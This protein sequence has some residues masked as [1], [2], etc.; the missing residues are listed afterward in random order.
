MQMSS[1]IN[2]LATHMGWK[3]TDRGRWIDPYGLGMCCENPPDPLNDANDCEALIGHLLGLGWS[4]VR[5]EAVGSVRVE[6]RNDNIVHSWHYSARDW[7]EGV[8]ELAV[9][10]LLTEENI[11]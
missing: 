9:R 11:E 6:L 1:Q 7:K 2:A 5:G 3:Q 4:F 8:V 10:A